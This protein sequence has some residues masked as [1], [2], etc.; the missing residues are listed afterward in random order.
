MEMGC[1]G[2]FVGSGIFKSSKPA[3]RAVAIVTACTYWQDPS[4][5][6]K[7]SEGLGKAM[8]GILHPGEK[9]ALAGDQEPGSAWPIDSPSPYRGLS[10]QIQ[11]R[12]RL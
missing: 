11:S 2:V 3:E 5:V 12:S 6:A 8:V 4:I 9:Y 10:A 1:D 7:C